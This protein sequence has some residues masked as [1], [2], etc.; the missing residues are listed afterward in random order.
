MSDTTTTDPVAETMDALKGAWSAY[1]DAVDDQDPLLALVALEQLQLGLRPAQRR[2]ATH[3]RHHRGGTYGGVAQA[4]GISTQAVY[5]RYG[6][7][8]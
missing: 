8:G 2:L 5:E 4:L 3:Y 1:I 6:R 7:K